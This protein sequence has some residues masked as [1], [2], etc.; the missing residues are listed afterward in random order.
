MTMSQAESIQSY[1]R[2]SYF[3]ILTPHQTGA[4][5]LE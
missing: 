2:S 3:Q 1:T 5:E 4:L